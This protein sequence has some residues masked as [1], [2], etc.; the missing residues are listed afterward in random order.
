[1]E[2]EYQMESSSSKFLSEGE[3]SD[4]KILELLKILFLSY[5]SSER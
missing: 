2:L 5:N 3:I 1:M 4:I